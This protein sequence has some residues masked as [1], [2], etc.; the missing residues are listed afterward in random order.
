LGTFLLKISSDLA[1]LTICPEAKFGL[2]FL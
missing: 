1:M 2:F